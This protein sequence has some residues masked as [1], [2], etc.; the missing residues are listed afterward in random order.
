MS[1]GIYTKGD[2]SQVLISTES[3][4]P[5]FIGKPTFVRKSGNTYNTYYFIYSGYTLYNEPV[6][7]FFEYTFDSGGRDAIFFIYAPYPNKCSIV[8]TS[9]SGSVYSITVCCQQG[10]GAFTPELYAFAKTNTVGNTGNGISVYRADG[11]TAFTSK[12]KILMIKGFY[13]GT[14]QYSNL[15]ESRIFSAYYVGNGPS[16]TSTTIN[17]INP[18]DTFTESISKP[19]VYLTCP[20]STLCRSDSVYRSYFYELIGLF[21]NSTKQIEIE[22]ASPSS[23]PSGSYI[24]PIQSPSRDAFFMVA[25][26][27]DYD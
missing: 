4:T 11:S 25:N 15:Q 13:N 27:A 22:W 3:D 9:K 7:S 26:G 1:F 18:T 2:Y 14:V 8:G 23:F 24:T 12:D 16:Y 5:V 19:I 20:Q 6:C 10:T 21:N 17:Y